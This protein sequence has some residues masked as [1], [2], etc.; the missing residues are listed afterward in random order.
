MRKVKY[1]AWDNVKNK[2]YQ[3]GEDDDVVF[4]FDSNGIL[5]ED[6]TEHDWGFK[7]LEHLIYIQYTG[8]EDKGG[9]GIYEGD[10]LSGVSAMQKETGRVVFDGGAFCLVILSSRTT[11]IGS[12]YFLSTCEELEVIGNIYA[13]PELLE[14]P[15]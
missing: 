2:M 3:V 10:V 15:E 8:L 9:R 13:N 11:G 1:R 5:A 12:K 7:K 6:L 14:V 4:S